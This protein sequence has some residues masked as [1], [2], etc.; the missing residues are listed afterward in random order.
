[1]STAVGC[2]TN[3][4]ITDVDF[5]W[6]SMTSSAE[7]HDTSTAVCLVHDDH[8]HHHSNSHHYDLHQGVPDCSTTGE[9]HASQC[10]GSFGSRTIFGSSVRP[11]KNLFVICVAYYLTYLPVVVDLVL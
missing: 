2:A 10:T 4:D 8:H 11:A 5:D 9:V 3:V 7:S 6:S 1:M